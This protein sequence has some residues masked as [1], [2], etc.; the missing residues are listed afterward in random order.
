MLLSSFEKGDAMGAKI[1]WSIVCLAVSGCAAVPELD[2]NIMNEKKYAVSYCLAEAYSESE[3]SRDARHVSGA[4]LQKGEFGIDVYERI[5]AFV[6]EYRKAP[7]ASKHGRNLSIM[8]CLDLF[9]SNELA[10]SVEQGANNANHG[11]R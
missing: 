6:D 8:Q 9:G 3:V 5:R 1:T 10:H 4:Y 2:Q 7:Y 11:D